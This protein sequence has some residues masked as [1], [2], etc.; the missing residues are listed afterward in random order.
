[1]LNLATKIEAGRQTVRVIGAG[2]VLSFLLG[3]VAVSAPKTY[4]FDR[5]LNQTH[6]FSAPASPTPEN[7]APK[8]EIVS[9][10][11]SPN[12]YDVDRFLNQSHPF[13]GTQPDRS[14]QASSDR[15]LTGP[16][17]TP[18]KLY[19]MDRAL[20]Q[21]HPFTIV[22]LP[23]V[24]AQPIPESSRTPLSDSDVQLD[25]L[26]GDGDDDN[27]PLESMNRFFFG[28]NE[29]LNTVLLGPI[30]HG[31]NAIFPEVVRT[32][33]ASFMD[34]LS[35]PVVLANDLLQGEFKRAG[36]TTARLAINSTIGIL[37]IIDVAEKFGFEKHGE[38]FG[39]TMAVWGVGEGFYL[40]LPIFGPSNPRDAIGIFGVDRF[41]DPLGYYL[42]NTNRDEYSYAR[43]GINGLV[44]YAGIVDDLDRLRETSVDFYGALRSLYRQR[45]NSEIGNNRAEEPQIPDFDEDIK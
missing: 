26:G 38:D 41:F 14:T 12:G 28:F 24:P 1:M 29:I 15:K 33:I 40:V 21:P 39:Q 30:A 35:S 9:P 3:N 34:N 4:N 37:G 17:I 2:L 45:R 11:I 8:S 44:T 20:N 7:P 36:D 23:V 43:T 5:F 31:Y 27:D 19:N 32:G 6:P 42:A 22:G 13:T 25:G 18:G 10:A 16:A